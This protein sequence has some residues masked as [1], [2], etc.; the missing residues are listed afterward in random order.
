M[1]PNS[2]MMTIPKPENWDMIVEYTK[3]DRAT[4]EKV[5]NARPDQAVVRRA[6]T[7]L[8][9]NMKFGNCVKNDGYIK[10]MGMNP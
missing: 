10:A 2:C 4:L 5:R 1:V 3:K 7:D 9:E 8:L 6:M